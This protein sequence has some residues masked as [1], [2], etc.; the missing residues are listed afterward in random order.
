MIFKILVQITFIAQL[1]WDPNCPIPVLDVING[2]NV[3]VVCYLIFEQ[4]QTQRLFV[5]SW[6]RF[7][8]YLLHGYWKIIAVPA[9]I[10]CSEASSSQ[11][12]HEINFISSENVSY[13]SSVSI[14]RIKK[15]RHFVV[16]NEL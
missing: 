13:C 15:R 11:L 14:S 5:C 3:G 1:H 10:N 7:S 16:Q 4:L 9:F 8:G 12:V 2:D 6:T